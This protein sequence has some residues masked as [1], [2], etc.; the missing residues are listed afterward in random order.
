MSNIESHNHVV[1]FAG[2]YTKQIHLGEQFLCLHIIGNSNI[3]N[4]ISRIVLQ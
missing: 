2:A 4:C 3:I 1:K